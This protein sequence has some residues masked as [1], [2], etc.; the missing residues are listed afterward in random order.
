VYIKL[1][2]QFVFNDGGRAA[3]GY[4]GECGDC[5]CRAIAIASGLPYAEVYT[6]LANGNDNTRITK[7]RKPKG[8]S[9]RNG[10]YVKTKWFKD[11]MAGIGFEWIPT[12]LVGQ[13]CKTHL[14]A[15]ELPA[16]RLVVSVA[17]HYTC[18]IDGVLNDT[19]NC[20]QH[21]AT[22]YPASC[23]INIP[24]GAVRLANGDWS[25]DPERCVYGYWIKI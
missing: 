3:S 10:V 20:S 25:Y 8:R 4:K 18:V 24:K 12:M 2:M 21:A 1:Y 17:K 13:G 14:N 7:R 9:A 15:S 23:L 11:Y 16:G 22:I 6:A 5:V 19:W